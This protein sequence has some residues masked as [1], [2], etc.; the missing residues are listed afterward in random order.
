MKLFLTSAGFPTN[1]LKTFFL[2]HLGKK[3]GEIKVVMIAYAKNPVELI[4]VNLSKREFR[5]MGF[6]NI[7][8]LNLTDSLS[9]EL[10]D[11]TDLVYV[12]GGNTFAI[13]KRLRE[14]KLDGKI[15]E[16]VKNGAIYV[17]VSAGSIIAGPNIE[18]AGW[19]SEGDT[20]EVGLTD[21]GGFSLT[22]TAVFP[23]Y[24]DELQA[25]VEEFR[26]KVSYQI[27]TLTNEQML[28]VEDGQV[29]LVQ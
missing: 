20:N 4:Y 12:C 1:N 5:G 18:I 24:H 14:T 29:E 7:L 28:F 25:E 27:E 10:L 2:D 3:P 15:I 22:N 11:D 23:H 21:L 13:L 9:P 26:K 8:M 17:G 19:G 16:L 6:E